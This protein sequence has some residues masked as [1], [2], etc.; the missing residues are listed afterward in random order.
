MSFIKIVL[1]GTTFEVTSRYTD[2]EP[3]GIGSFGLV[4]SAKDQF[5]G[6]SLAIKKIKK[7]SRSPVLSR[8]A[9]REL[10][11]L[12]SFQHENI[13]NL[14]DVMLSPMEDLY[15]VT[16]L[17]DTDLHA[18]LKARSLEERFTQYF[19]YQI[20]RGLKYIHSAGI[21]HRDIVSDSA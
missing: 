9:Y 1:F 6:L 7:P 4:C 10:M 19:L 5:T 15:L 13:I 20:L 2:L 18:L 14:H 3:V 11:L 8:L 17:L 16:D 12:K 21:V